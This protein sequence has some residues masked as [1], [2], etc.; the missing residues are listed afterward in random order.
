MELN[1]QLQKLQTELSGF[2]GKQNEELKS[3]GT[4]TT[5]TKTVIETLSHQHKDL[6]KQVNAMQVQM[7][8]PGGGQAESKSILDAF[9]EKRAHI[10][11]VADAGQGRVGIFSFK[12]VP[13]FE[14]KTLIDSTALGSG[15]AGVIMPQKVGGIIPGAEVDLRMRDILP[16]GQTGSNAVFFVKENAFTNSASPQTEGSAKGES[17]LT[18]TTDTAPVRTIAHWIPV[19]RQALDDMRELAGY[20]NRKL[21]YGLKLKEDDELLNGSGSGLHLSGLTTEA[22]AFD[23]A[24]MV[25]ASAGWNKAD[26]IRRAIQQLESAN[27]TP[28]DFIVLNPVNWADIELT[29]ATT[30]EY[31][32]G[33]AFNPLSKRLW[34]KPV[35][36]TNAMASGH[37]LVGSSMQAQIWDRMGVEVAISTEHSTYFTE[38]KVAIRVE[39]RLALA[40][41]RPSAFIYGSLNTSP[42]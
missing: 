10:K 32:A 37:F 31:V 21:I 41:Y 4:V 8:N 15:V 30:Y 12:D 5:E 14:R 13:E 26:V 39:E 22:T 16:S 9:E 36:T 27:E 18:F 38:N 1:E 11:A 40:V 20:V 29:K 2:I 23:T 25:P 24:L 34:G 42:A 28:A 7:A 6:Q 17:A 35:I 3:I 19:T 33:N